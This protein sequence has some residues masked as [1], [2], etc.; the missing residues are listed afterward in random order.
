MMNKRS[1]SP[2]AT[3]HPRFHSNWIIL[4]IL[5]D[6]PLQPFIVVTPGHVTANARSL[7]YIPFGFQ[8][9]RLLSGILFSRIYLSLSSK[10]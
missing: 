6:C 5:N 1:T 9:R 7:A 4:E 10:I 3:T 2:M 8:R